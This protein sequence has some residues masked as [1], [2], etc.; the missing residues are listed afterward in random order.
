M[1][2]VTRGKLKL[3]EPI[4]A[5]LPELPPTYVDVTLRRL[6]DHQSGVF[7]E[8]EAIFFDMTHYAT[9]RASLKA[10]VDSPLK[11]KPGTATQYSSQGVTVAGAA[12]ESVTGQSFQQLSADFFAA[13]GLPGISLDDNFRIVPNRV[14]GY[15]VDRDSKTEIDGKASSRDYLSGTSGAITNARD[16]DISAR[17]PAGGFVASGDDLMRFVLAVGSGKVLPP[18]AMEE[19]WSAQ[20]TFDGAETVF[21]IGWGVSKWKGRSMVG[22]NG[23][24]PSTTTLLRYFPTEGVG[25]AVLCNAEGAKD[26]A[27]L[28]DAL[29]EATFDGFQ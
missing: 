24:T 28:M 6:L 13:K 18:A 9:S 14:R 27:D 1:D 29:L 5:Y 23:A 3:D 26:L 25:A 21:G 11:F 12:A 22:M 17:Y 2:L 16:Y 20:K 7:H 10:F 15:F 19:M 4:R 8:S